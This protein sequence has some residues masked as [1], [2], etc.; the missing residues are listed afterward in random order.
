MYTEIIAIP[1]SKGECQQNETKAGGGDKKTQQEPALR[2]KNINRGCRLEKAG[3]GEGCK[4][5]HKQ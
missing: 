4:K 1:N 5:M 2:K 3:G